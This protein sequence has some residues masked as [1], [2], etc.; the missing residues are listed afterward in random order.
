MDRD[1][2]DSHRYR[3]MG[4]AVTVNASPTTSETALEVLM[5]AVLL[6]LAAGISAAIAFDAYVRR[7]E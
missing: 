1:E 3:Q 5:M 7:V 2:R 4:N 6:W